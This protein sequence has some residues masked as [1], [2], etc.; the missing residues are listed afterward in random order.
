M[1]ELTGKEIGTGS[2]GEPLL[3]TNTIKF[4]R[5][6]NESSTLAIINKLNKKV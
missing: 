4:T 2:D 3:D 1:Y 5:W 6:V